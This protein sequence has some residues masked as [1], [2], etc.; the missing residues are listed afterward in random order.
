MFHDLFKNGAIFG[1]AV[2]FVV[3][4]ISAGQY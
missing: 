4:S 1:G 2:R 3:Q